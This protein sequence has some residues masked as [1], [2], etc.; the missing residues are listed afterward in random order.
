MIYVK[1]FVESKIIAKLSILRVIVITFT[2]LRRDNIFRHIVT[3][4]MF[5]GL[6]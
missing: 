4:L 1:L 5:S 3:T 6:F 2:T